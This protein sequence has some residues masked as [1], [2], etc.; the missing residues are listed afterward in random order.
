MTKRQYHLSHR[1]NGTEDEILICRP[2][3]ESIAFLQFWDESDT[4]ETERAVKTA[5]HIIDA[6]NAYPKPLRV[7]RQ[8][9][10]A[11]RGEEVSVAETDETFIPW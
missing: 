7:P 2:N 1:R 10:M 8:K 6:L 9:I 4:N 3:G 5:L 11:E